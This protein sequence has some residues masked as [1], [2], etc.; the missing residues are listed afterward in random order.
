MTFPGIKKT[1]VSIVLVCLSAVCSAQ[2][3][4]PRQ[5]D[6]LQIIS[7]RYNSMDI[8]R[9][10]WPCEMIYM[11]TTDFDICGQKFKIAY[12]LD[13]TEEYLI[14]AVKNLKSHMC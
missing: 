4:P 6:T 10:N 2:L 3:Q 9:E 11:S 12:V 14:S 13:Y 5:T 1:A 7:I 8:L